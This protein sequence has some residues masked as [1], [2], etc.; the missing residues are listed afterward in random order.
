[1]MSAI[2]GRVSHFRLSFSLLL[3]LPVLFSCF[4][5]F[6]AK[7]TER[8]RIIEN[9]PFYPQQAFQ[10]GPASLAGVLNYWGLKVSPEQIS[11]NIYSQSAKGTLTLDMVFYAQKMDFEV[12]WYKGNLGDI[13][14]HIDSGYPL[15]V[16]VDYGF[17]AY[18]QNHFMVVLGY[19][20]TSVIVNSGK[21][22]H[23]FVSQEKFL[24]EWRKGGFWTF[25]IKPKE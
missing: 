9:V 21:N 5:N 14:K 10:C 24:K 18:Q 16:L 7:G 25:L 4:G 3:I 15:I 23:K 22:H 1:M 17:L 12:Q 6:K 13:K 11:E 20:D 19:N 8:G 2:Q